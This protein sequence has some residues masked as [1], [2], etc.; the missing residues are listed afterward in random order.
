MNKEIKKAW[1]RSVN[2]KDW[3]PTK[4]PKYGNKIPGKIR[5]YHFMAYNVLR[6]YP[7]GVGFNPS[8]EKYKSIKYYYHWYRD[9][10]PEELLFPFEGLITRE[11]LVK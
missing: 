3:K 2:N 7:E 9:Y 11:D 1:S 8:T 6:G 5:N 10:K 4:D